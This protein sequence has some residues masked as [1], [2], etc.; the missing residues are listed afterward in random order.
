MNQQTNDEKTILKLTHDIFK[1][2]CGH[3]SWIIKISEEG[4]EESGVRD[5]EKLRDKKS[6][7]SRKN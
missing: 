3:T 1:V 5:K 6:T 7:R 2:I 4:D